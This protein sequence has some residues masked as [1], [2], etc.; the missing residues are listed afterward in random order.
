MQTAVEHL[1]TVGRAVFGS[2]TAA[3][4]DWLGVQA[5]TF[6]HGDPEQVL[7]A[8]RSLDVT[9]AVDAQ[10]ATLRADALAYIGDLLAAVVS[11]WQ[12]DAILAPSTAG[13]SLGVMLG[14]RLGIRLH[15]S[16]VG[17]DGRPTGILGMRRRVEALDGTLTVTSLPGGPT[18]IRVELPCAS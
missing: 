8:L 10:A 7:V 9:R 6:K 4:R 14:R 12:P 16:N 5:H 3:H 11:N 1:A 18:T 15:L 2:G 17:D 13:V